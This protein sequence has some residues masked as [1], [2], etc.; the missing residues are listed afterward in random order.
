MTGVG[1][2]HVVGEAACDRELV[3]EL[4][5]ALKSIQSRLDDIERSTQA[6]VKF[7]SADELS[8]Q[9]MLCVMILRR[10]PMATSRLPFILLKLGFS[11]PRWQF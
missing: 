8:R 1:V 7:I 6:F 2:E 11:S 10:S 9:V 4:F 3:K 5:G